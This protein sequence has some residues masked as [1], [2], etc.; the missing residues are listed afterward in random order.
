MSGWTFLSNH[1]HV[2]LLLAREPE[3]RMREVAARVD[4]TERAVQRIISE[5]VE[6]GYVDVSKEGRRN[7]YTV[8]P[9]A[10][11][12]HPLEHGVTIGDLADLL[13][14]RAGTR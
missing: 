13:R 8:D 6:E 7:V 5:L 12:R 10:G 9:A 1:A 3:L 14:E 2:L 11:L 4:I